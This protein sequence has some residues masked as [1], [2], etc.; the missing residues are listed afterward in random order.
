[1]SPWTLAL[2]VLW[3]LTGVLGLAAGEELRQD[4]PQIVRLVFWI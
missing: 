4:A 1:M 2:A 3:A